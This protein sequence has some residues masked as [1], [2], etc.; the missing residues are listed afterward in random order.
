MTSDSSPNNSALAA[1]QVRKAEAEL[2]LLEKEVALRDR[3]LILRDREVKRKTP[4]SNPLNT[5]DKKL[6]AATIFFLVSANVPLITNTFR[7]AWRILGLPTVPAPAYD[8]TK[9]NMEGMSLFMSNRQVVKRDLAA[10]VTEYQE[11]PTVTPKAIAGYPVTS[12]FGNR[13]HPVSKEVKHHNGIDLGTPT[14][15]KLYGF[16]NGL[17][18]ECRKGDHEGLAAYIDFKPYTIALFHLNDCRNGKMKI[19]ESFAETGSSGRGT[20][21]HLHFELRKDNQPVAPHPKLIQAVL[22]GALPTSDDSP[23]VKLRKAIISQESQGNHEAVNTDSFAVG[24]GQVM[25]ENIAP[26]T[27]ECLGK[28]ISEA[29]FKVSPKLQL[30]VIDCKLTQY[31]EAALKESKTPDEAIRRV[32]SQWYS[33]QRD[34]FDDPTPQHYNGNPYPSIRDYTLSVLEKVKKM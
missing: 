15:T 20:G 23:V 13:V 27:K 33:G 22:N 30:A 18:V 1:I 6:I 8:P 29:D 34:W 19:G 24:Y 3:D 5:L 11:L 14:G 26:W 2:A 31:Y 10:V 17:T 21:E 16:A 4:L 32:A 25:P 7:I 12:D 28:T 9:E